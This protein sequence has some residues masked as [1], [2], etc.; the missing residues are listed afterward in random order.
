MSTNGTFVGLQTWG[1]ISMVT[2]PNSVKNNAVRPKYITQNVASGV[3]PSTTTNHTGTSTTTPAPVNQML[4]E[5]ENGQLFGTATTVQDASR[6]NSAYVNLESGSITWTDSLTKAGTYNIVLNM[7]SPYGPKTNTFAIDGDSASFSVDSSV[8]YGPDTV[9][10]AVPLAAGKHT[11]FLDA[12]WGWINVDYLQLIPATATAALRSA[13]QEASAHGLYPVPGGVQATGLIGIHQIQ[14]MDL[15]G[16]LLATSNPQAYSTTI[17][18][19]AHGM[20]LVSF[21]DARGA[22]SRSNLVM[23]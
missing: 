14:V 19:R 8:T 13:P 18:V 12:S 23:P 1:L 7:D 2:D 22:I 10:K 5:A 21:E 4:L 16:R 20:V 3:F 15:S 11:F 17:P 6:S 9:A